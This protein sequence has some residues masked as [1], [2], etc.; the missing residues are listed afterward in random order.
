MEFFQSVITKILSMGLSDLIAM[1][2]FLFV[3]KLEIKIVL[4]I[5]GA[6]IVLEVVYMIFSGIDFQQAQSLLFLV[7]NNI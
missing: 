7:F 3:L 2:I 6:L 5:V 1:F 4:K